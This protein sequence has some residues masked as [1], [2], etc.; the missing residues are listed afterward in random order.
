MST[1]DKNYMKLDRTG[2]EIVIREKEIST[3][4]LH[5]ILNSSF[6]LRMDTWLQEESIDRVQILKKI[7]SNN[8]PYYR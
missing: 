2:N 5:H 3:H 7:Q 6:L 1:K 4:R 8:I